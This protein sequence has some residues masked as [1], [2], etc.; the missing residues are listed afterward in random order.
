MDK[1][2]LRENEFL[3]K[4]VGQDHVD[5]NDTQFWYHL[6]SR[7]FNFMRVQDPKMVD[8]TL[9]PYLVRLTLNNP[10][11]LNI[12]SLIR[13]FFDRV[14]HIKSTSD[15]QST[16]PHYIFQSFNALYLLRTICKSYIETLTEEQL[17][18]ALRA[19]VDPASQPEQTIGGPQTSPPDFLPP[20]TQ[21]ANQQTS[22]Q[23]QTAIHQGSNPISPE[24][25]S[26]TSPDQTTPCI[27]PS[28]EQA[29]D[30]VQPF[31]MNEP[32]TAIP[33]LPLID[34]QSATECLATKDY[35]TAV[36]QSPSN[37]VDVTPGATILDQYISTLIAIIVDVPHDDSS[38][39]LKVEAINALLVLLSV[40]MYSNAP[41][42]QIAI[43]KCLM[44][45]RCSIHAL[46]LTKTLLN[47][48]V[49]Q[50]PAPQETG[51]LIIGLASGLWKVLTL[52]YGG[53]E[54]EN[55][56]EMPPLARQSLLLLNILTNHCTSDEKNPYREAMT[57]CQDS[58]FNLSDP[59]HSFSNAENDVMATATTSKSAL[60]ANSIKIDFH[61]LL[62]TLCNHLDND[63]VALLLYMLLQSN[64][65]FRPYILTTASDELDKLLLPLLKILYSSIERGS[66][67]VYMVL[68]IFIMLSEERL[69][70]EAI[71]K[72]TLRNISWYKDKVFS[73]ISLASFTTL[74]LIRSFQYNTFRMKDKFLHSNLFA[75]LANLSNYFE[76]LHPYVCQ[77]LVEFLER[78]S[79]RYLIMTR[80]GDD[81]S[82]FNGLSGVAF[83]SW[84]VPLTRA[85][86]TQPSQ[87][88]DVQ[89]ASSIELDSSHMSSDLI[90][91]PGNLGQA[92]GSTVNINMSEQQQPLPSQPQIPWQ[93]E[94]Q[95]SPGQQSRAPVIDTSSASNDETQ[96]SSQQLSPNGSTTTSDQIR[97]SMDEN[98]Q[99]MSMICEVIKMLLEV[100]N[101]ILVVRLKENPDLIYTLLYKR[102]VFSSLLS[103]HSSFYN[104]VINVER[105]LTYAYNQID[106]FGR[107]LTVGEIKTLIDICINWKFEQHKDSNAR[108]LFHYVE[109]EQPED[110]FIPYIWTRVYYSSQ[111]FWDSK[112]IVLFNPYDL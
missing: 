3:E 29:N 75:T 90:R 100:I 77:R 62:E 2:D 27:Q 106:A 26:T 84:S 88:P 72:I 35:S 86:S 85:L 42:S 40:Q 50:Q 73:E 46:V 21:N 30:Q 17:I 39:H 87:E 63:Q 34:S 105:V 69:F 8:K 18:K 20:L 80:H 79:K 11:S 51:S 37:K 98:S 16:N 64:R 36:P 41:A 83:E 103:S 9:E 52:G 91:A 58:R 60:I 5:S 70:N 89:D 76:S 66:H 25:P 49:S 7:S 33:S 67:H 104:L 31:A 111:I 47:N 15:S 14:S 48:F 10:Q 44:Q 108:L 99:D 22:V 4:F 53:V 82:Q 93:Q 54:E 97:I 68:I 78:L 12:G 112:R 6:L 59:E 23:S 1:I 107:P 65:I 55:G 28:P 38:Y 101:N 45:K 24:Q 92:N 61:R 32:G 57:S 81:K 102:E 95:V 94:Q 71:Q 96:S 109:D 56:D 19:R 110:F 43:Y 74:I 13:V